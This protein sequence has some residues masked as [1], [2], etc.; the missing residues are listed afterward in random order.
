MQSYGQVA[1]ASGTLLAHLLRGAK[2]AELAASFKVAPY[3]RQSRPAAGLVAR[4]SAGRPFPP[5]NRSF[6]AY[7]I[8]S[9]PFTAQSANVGDVVAVT[10]AVR[11]LSLA[12]IVWTWERSSIQEK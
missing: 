6:V 10:S 7:P 2:K 8:G 4:G 9:K 3:V 5:L 1:D 12:D 11:A